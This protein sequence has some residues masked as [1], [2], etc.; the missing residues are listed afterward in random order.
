MIKEIFNLV[1]ALPFP[2][3]PHAEAQRRKGRK[4]IGFPFLATLPVVYPTAQ[5]HQKN[6]VPVTLA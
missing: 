6:L 5:V 4:G 2:K 1:N 3:E